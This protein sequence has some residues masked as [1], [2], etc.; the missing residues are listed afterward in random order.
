MLPPKKETKKEEVDCLVSTLKENRM[1]YT[2]RKFDR[3]KA[4]RQ[5]KHITGLPTETLKHVL[6]QNIIK[7]CP[8]T[9]ED[10]NIAERIFGPDMGALKGKSTRK[11]PAAVRDDV[12]E[13]PPE[14]KEQHADLTF[15]M[16]LM[17][18][19]GMPFL[20][21]IDRSIRYREI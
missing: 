6:R 13:I 17:F 1:G 21:G 2:Q 10:V 16:D 9:A 15:C 3:A 5:L 18:V 4:A 7:N 14:I 8:V 11:T 12:V 19:N 20:T